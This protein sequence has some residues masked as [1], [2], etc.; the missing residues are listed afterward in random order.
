MS[1]TRWMNGWL[2][3]PPPWNTYRA[4]MDCSLV[5][6]DKSPGVRPVVIGDMLFRSRSKLGMRSAGYQAK[7]ARRNLQLYAGL[8]SGIE[9]ATYNVR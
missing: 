5:A 3:P 8:K 1:L 4:L 2:T 6:M 7:T 9:R